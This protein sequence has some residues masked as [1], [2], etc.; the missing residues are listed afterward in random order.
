MGALVW[1]CALGEQVV[2]ALHCRSRWVCAGRDSYWP[3]V[4]VECEA[5]T[6][7]V[8][9]VGALSSYWP[10][11]KSHAVSRWH[12]RSTFHDGAPLCHSPS[13]HVVSCEHWR[14]EVLEL[15]VVRF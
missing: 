10:A 6:L 8:S 1:Y 7:S 3:D 4:H 13:A 12:A 11:W 5:Q 15:R 14:S 2:R 9:H